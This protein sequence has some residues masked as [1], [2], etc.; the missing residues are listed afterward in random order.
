MQRIHTKISTKTRYPMSSLVSWYKGGLQRKVA[1]KGKTSF[2]VPNLI[3]DQIGAGGTKSGKA[4]GG[5]PDTGGA[6]GYFPSLST[7]HII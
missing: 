4:V 1:S 6:K 2:I 3:L 7:L 5:I